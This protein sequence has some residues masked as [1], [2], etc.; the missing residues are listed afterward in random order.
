MLWM[1][2]M[3]FHPVKVASRK[4]VE[5][6]FCPLIDQIASP[7]FTTAKPVERVFYSLTWLVRDGRSKCNS[8]LSFLLFFLS[9]IFLFLLLYDWAF[10]KVAVALS[11]SSIW[12]WFMNLVFVFCFDLHSRLQNTFKNTLEPKTHTLG[13][14]QR[15]RGRERE[16][17]RERKKK[18]VSIL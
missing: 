6:F 17:E 12:I 4:K 8:L 7:P 9:L 10:D 2:S 18:R 11:L 3:Y 5:Q 14:T 13:D 15:G 1:Q 16:R